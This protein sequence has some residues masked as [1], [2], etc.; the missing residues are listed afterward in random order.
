MLETVALYR[1]AVILEHNFELVR[2][3]ISGFSG[4][5]E[6]SPVRVRNGS[7]RQ[8]QGYLWSDVPAG[9]VTEFLISYKTHPAAHKVN[10]LLLAE[11]IT[12]MSEEQ[13]LTKWT[14]VLIG[15]GEGKSVPIIDDIQIETLKRSPKGEYADRYSIGRLLSPRDEAIDL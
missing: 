12:S 5:R 8:W 2:R 11:F 4:P 1:D 14:V 7:R 13:E 6:D 10:S 3:L 15:G 9:D